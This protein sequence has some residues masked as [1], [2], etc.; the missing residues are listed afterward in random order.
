MSLA[1]DLAENTQQAGTEQRPALTFEQFG[2]DD[3]V[4]EAALVLEGDEQRALGGAGA[5]PTSDDAGT[6]GE[7]AIRAVEQ[8]AGA[9]EA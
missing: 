4:G 2:S 8:L 1:T 9:H 5:L 6:A 7:L 3:D